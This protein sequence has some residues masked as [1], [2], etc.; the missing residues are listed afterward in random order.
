MFRRWFQSPT[1]AAL[2]HIQRKQEIIMATLADIRAAVEA[3]TTVDQ[4][5]ITLLG[6]LKDKLDEAIANGADPA[7]LQAIADELASNTQALS[8]AVTANTPAE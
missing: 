3:Q 2:T 5:V 7:E 8:E 6:E 4:S 1:L